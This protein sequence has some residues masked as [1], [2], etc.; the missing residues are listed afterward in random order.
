M[1][2]ER[3][4]RTVTLLTLVSRVAGLARDAAL[5]RVFGVSPLMDAFWFAFAIPNLFRRLFGEG[6]LTAAFIPAYTELT[7]NNPSVAK[8]LATL[9][10]SIMMIV[11]GG[12]VLLTE[13]VL[14]AVAERTGG[15]NIAVWLTMIMLPYMP[16][17]CVVAIMGAILQVHGKFGPTA[18]A[19]I[20]LNLCIVIASVVGAKYF[21]HDDP[22][23]ELNH[24]ATVAISVLVAGVLQVLWS[25]WALRGTGWWT[26]GL[27]TTR[28]AAPA[29]KR[30]MTQ[31]L[32][33]FLGLG[34]LQI[35]TFLDDLIASYPTTVGP[36]IFGITFPLEE[37]AL[38][39]MNAA[40][41]LHEFPLG[42]FGIAIATAIFPALARVADDGA[43][44]GDILRRGLRLVIYIGLPASVGLMLVRVPLTAA[45]FQGGKFDADDT[46]R[47]SRILLGFAPAIW[48]YSM[49]HTVTRAFFAKGDAITPVKV[50]VGVVMLNFL[51]NITLIWTPLKEAG[52]A[53]STATCAIIQTVILLKLSRRFVEGGRPVDDAVRSSWIK[54][55]IVTAVM[56]AAVFAI[57]QWAIP[58]HAITWRWAMIEL[59]ILVPTG[60]AVV[61]VMSKALRMPELGWAMGR[62]GK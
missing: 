49:T 36:T 41:R 22:K 45:V 8:Q 31:F 33:M 55:V 16:L 35:N 44:F 47:V 51:L 17:V 54:S 57:Q 27:K 24:V 28:E 6:A 61:V 21:N 5:S 15:D 52:L 29:F 23:Q 53:W 4:A 42:V 19:P 62:T 9:T 59:A 48:A 18:A 39:A 58:A 50:A 60:A 10:V 20:V 1:A 43:A 34:V 25:V 3:H 30:V 56:A 2:F 26:G 14:L 11:L 37:G 7:K 46:L 32:P 12:V 13:C 40:Q 38:T